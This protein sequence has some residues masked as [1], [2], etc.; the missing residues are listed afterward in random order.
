MFRAPKGGNNYQRDEHGVRNDI[1]T[2]CVTRLKPV[3]CSTIDDGYSTALAVP[4]PEKIFTSQQ[5]YVYYQNMRR[6]VRGSDSCSRIDE[7]KLMCQNA[8]LD[9]SLQ[10]IVQKA[11]R[12]A[13]LYNGHHPITAVHPGTQRMYDNL[14]R[15][16]YWS[17]MALDVYS[18]VGKY[19]SCYKNR[20]LQ[21]QQRRMH[22]FPSKGSLEFETNGMLRPLTRT[23]Q[24]NRF[25]V[26]IKDRYSR[27]TRV[28]SIV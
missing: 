10:A 21:T 9:S 16:F 18:Y 19:E 15:Q 25:V 14:R 12:Q 13:V 8:P 24:E 3:A 23:R 28:I 5:I 22:L 26:V 11:L 20:L 6:L 1:P 17:H 2:K 4:T 27:L 7:N